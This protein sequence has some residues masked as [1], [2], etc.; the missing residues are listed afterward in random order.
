MGKKVQK[1]RNRKDNKQAKVQ[2]ATTRRRNLRKHRTKVQDKQRRQ[3]RLTA[4]GLFVRLLK[5]YGYHRNSDATN[6]TEFSKITDD[7][8]AHVVT[9]DYIPGKAALLCVYDGPDAVCVVQKVLYYDEQPLPEATRKVLAD[10]AESMR[11][12]RLKQQWEK[13]APRQAEP[14]WKAAL[15]EQTTH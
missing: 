12:A 1:L 9:M 7:G 14:A 5:E 6:K 8:Q 3:R 4:G 13:E 15:R 2:Q 11:V 10:R